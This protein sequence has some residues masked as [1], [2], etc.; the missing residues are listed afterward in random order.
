M[1]GKEKGH[2]KKRYL[3]ITLFGEVFFFFNAKNMIDVVCIS[4]VQEAF[5]RKI[6]H[7]NVRDLIQNK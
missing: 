5:I 7:A 3:G 1:T 4:L 6:I 2:S